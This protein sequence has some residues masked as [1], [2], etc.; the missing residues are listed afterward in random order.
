MNK[1][2]EY[3]NDPAILD[4]LSA[5]RNLYSAAKRW[6][7]V[8]FI[9]CVFLIVV[10]SV[11]KSIWSD[12]SVLAI[13][14]AFAIFISLLLGP[15]FNKQINKRRN[16]AARIQQLLDIELFDQPW[17]EYLCGRQPAAEDVFDNKTTKI[18]ANLY[19]WYDKGIG[20]VKDLNT[21]V[22]LCQRE[23]MRYDSH[24]RT[25]FTKLCKWV[26]V[27]VCFGIIVT[28]VLIYKTDILSVV[29]FGLIPITPIVRWIQAVMNEDSKDKEV[30]DSLESLV[31]KEM[32]NAMKGKQIHV[33]ELKRIQNWMFMHRRD[34]YLVPDWYYNVCREKSEDRA[35]YSVKDFLRQYR[36]AQ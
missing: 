12:C 4:K 1:I 7:N 5:Q 34:G 9:C 20:E 14:L 10:L 32:D 35:A 36:P 24:I 28:A 21:A 11:L 27:I 29:M 33:T 25:A 16:L 2:I 8:R 6:R 19:D 26:A 15:V 13:I 17:D 31:A 23:N 30:R 22:L 3:Q 18:P